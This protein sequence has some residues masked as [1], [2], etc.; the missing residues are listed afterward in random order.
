MVD[1]AARLMNFRRGE[2]PLGVQAALFYFC[3][4]CGYFFL[5][6]V[7]D[8]MGVSR[9]MDELRWLFVVTSISSLVVVLL[10]GGVVSKLDRRKFIPIGYLFVI[11]CLSAFSALLIFDAGGGGGLIGTDAGN[12]CCP[13]RGIHV[14]RLALRHQPV[15]QQPFLGLHGRCVQRRPGQTHVCVHRDRWNVGRHLGRLVNQRDQR[16]DR[17]C[18]PAGRPDA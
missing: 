18:L 1:R 14:L 3:V 8:A 17:I 5:R 9:G 13:R 12:Q 15:R 2:L 11:A 4:L 7:R 16:D 6:P 10:F